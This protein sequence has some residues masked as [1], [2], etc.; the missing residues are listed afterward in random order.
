[1]KQKPI[2]GQKLF[3]LNVGNSA[4]NREQVLTPV[5]VVKVGRKYFM[6]KKNVNDPEWCGTEYSIDGWNEKT[7]YT[8]N[9]HL[10]ISEQEYKDEIEHRAICKMISDAFDWRSFSKSS[11]KGKIT[12][13]ALRKIAEIIN[14]AEK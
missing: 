8:A 14:E 12:L 11:V 3:S 7:E 2:V 10:Y 9:S 13:E 6:V 5:E 4:R 1:M